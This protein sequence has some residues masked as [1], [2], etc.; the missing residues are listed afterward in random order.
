MGAFLSF[1]FQSR[2]T[3]NRRGGAVTR[4][5]DSL[6]IVKA[7]QMGVYFSTKNQAY[8]DIK[9]T[10][11]LLCERKMSY[12][13]RKSLRDVYYYLLS[14]LKLVLT[15]WILFLFWYSLSKLKSS[16][17]VT[18]CMR[19][20]SNTCANQQNFVLWYCDVKRRCLPPLVHTWVNID[21]LIWESI[22]KLAREQPEVPIFVYGFAPG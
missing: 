12:F 5:W 6:L 1:F 8:H 4:R 2:Q 16:E 15:M 20:K 18:H 17:E 13:Q 11:A 3:G 7:K 21:L 10:S 9:S 22:Q 19:H 14:Q